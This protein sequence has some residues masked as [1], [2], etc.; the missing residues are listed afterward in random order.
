MRNPVPETPL[1]VEVVVVVIVAMAWPF[2][3]KMAP[4]IL[5]DLLT[6]LQKHHDSLKPPMAM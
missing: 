6:P 5:S 3:E 1:S 2:P 4:F